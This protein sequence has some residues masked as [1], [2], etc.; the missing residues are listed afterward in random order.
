MF[1]WRLFPQG[2]QVF[3]DK[4]I[5]VLDPQGLFSGI[6]LTLVPYFL[7]DKEHVYPP[8]IDFGTCASCW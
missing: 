6:T 2:S 1:F 7:I 8:P 5:Q 4:R 3:F